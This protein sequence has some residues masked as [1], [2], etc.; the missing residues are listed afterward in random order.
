MGRLPCTVCG[1]VMNKHNLKHHQQTKHNIN[2]TVNAICC[3]VYMEKVLKHVKKLIHVNGNKILTCEVDTYRQEMQIAGRSGMKGR[4]C[5]HS[6]AVNDAL[7][8]K[9]H[10]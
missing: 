8:P 7:L 4:E 10:T 9:H 3:D 1:S 5:S 6:L 2:K